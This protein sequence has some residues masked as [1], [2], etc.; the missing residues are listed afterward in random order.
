MTGSHIEQRVSETTDATADLHPRITGIRVTDVSGITGTLVWVA[1]AV[2]TVW[3]GFAWLSLP[4]LFVSLAV[5]VLV[6]LGLGIVGAGFQYEQTPLAYRLAVSGQLPAALAAVGALALPVGTMSA[7]ALAL[8]WLAVTG[9]VALVGVH[10]LFSRG[11]TAG[12]LPELAADA[13]LLYVPVGAVALVLHTADVTFHFK[14]IIILLTVVHYHYAGFVLP[15]VAGMAGR[16]VA[17]EQG[18]FGETLLGR[19]MAAT[20]LV[21]VVNLALIAVGITF[22][23]LVEVVAVAFFTVAVA[24]FALCILFGVGPRVGRGRRV[25][26]S[27]AALS[28]VWTMAL[29]LAYGYSAYPGTPELLTLNEMILR[30]GSVNAFG[31]ALPTLLAFRWRTPRRR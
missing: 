26:L 16:I 6:P 1:L 31:F 3:S 28:I 5:L 13:A 18:H 9:C 15:L 21:V 27:I 19:A 7:V 14:P 10:R 11:V 22:S 4:E 29:A 2:L 17:D 30:H 23:P 25:L 8:P 24:I 20:T 12:P